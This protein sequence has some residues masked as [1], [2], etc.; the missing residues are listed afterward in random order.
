MRNGRN[1][2][3]LYLVQLVELGYVVQDHRTADPFDRRQASLVKAVVVERNLDMAAYGWPGRLRAELQTLL[4]RDQAG[5]RLAGQ[6]PIRKLQCRPAG[7]VD[8]DDA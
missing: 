7:L 8:Q 4:L 3:R 1:N 5:Q 2:I 6:W